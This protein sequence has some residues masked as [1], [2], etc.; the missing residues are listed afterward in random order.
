MDVPIKTFQN[1]LSFLS[2]LLVFLL[3]KIITFEI[4]NLSSPNFL[5]TYFI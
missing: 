4:G 1:T 2:I 3:Y 5:H